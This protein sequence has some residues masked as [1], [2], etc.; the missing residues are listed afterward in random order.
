MS[1]NVKKY[2][3]ILRRYRSG[4]FG[5]QNLCIREILS[6]AGEPDL[7]QKMDYGE[8]TELID[9][10]QSIE[11]KINLKAFR[12][13]KF[14]ICPNQVSSPER[15]SDRLLALKGHELEVWK[16]DSNYICVAY[17]SCEVK[18]G[19][20]L[21]YEPGRGSTFEEACED[22][23]QKISGKTLVFDACT[24]SRKEVTVL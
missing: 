6:K 10:V 16:D 23:L 17:K 11:T 3:D 18:N 4:E 13:R 8:L 15:A 24:A 21:I 19:A 1:D 14:N 22:Y 9:S 12:D 5:D 7:L 20:F 2:M